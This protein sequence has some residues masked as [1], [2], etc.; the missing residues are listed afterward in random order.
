MDK[1]PEGT[2]TFDRSE[3]QNC[4][5]C[6]KG[7]AHSR[8]VEFYEV[9]ITQVV[10]DPDAIRQI[11]ASEMM[12]GDPVIGAILAPTSRIGV[13]LPEKRVL[14]CHTCFFERS[15]VDVISLWVED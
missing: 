9:K 13:R 2:K 10:L 8:A 14:L 5:V 4:A 3:I 1:L 11:T 7:V 12:A 15:D 6:K